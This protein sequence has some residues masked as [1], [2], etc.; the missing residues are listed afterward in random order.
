MKKI[1]LIGTGGTIASKPSEAGLSPALSIAELLEKV[2]ETRAMCTIDCI[3]AFN[4][5]STNIRP[6]HWIAIAKIIEDNY[7]NYDGFVL[8][9]GTDTMAYTAAGLSYL[10]QNSPKPIV[11]TGSQVSVAMGDSDARRNLIDAFICASDPRSHGV[12]VVFSGS[13]IL[14]T[15]ARKNYTKRFSAFVSS[16]FPEVARIQ[17]GKIFWFIPLDPSATT[18]TPT[19]YTTLN[20]N[21]GLIKLFPGITEDVLSFMIDRYDALV[22]ECFGVG[23]LPE[24]YEF[25]SHIRLAS[26]R[27][28]LF[29]LTTQ[30]PNEG[31]DLSIYKVGH[32]LI[33]IPNVIDAHDMTSESCV[34][35]LMWCLANSSDI[36]TAV[37]MFTTPIA[38]DLI[39]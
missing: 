1:L 11:I 32:R 35:K 25:A 7:Q 4:I 18:K 33:D 22:L 34:T 15:R 29:V 36:S 37:R 30:V 24:Y 21:V 19:F 38:H 39:T 3:Q 27:G 23:G 5:D 12:L 8:T 9:H 26:E 13:V 10:I 16:N 28:T 14:G 20:P 17:S 6:E 31:S 2:P